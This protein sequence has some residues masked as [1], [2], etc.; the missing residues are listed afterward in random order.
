L[1]L[2]SHFLKA[3]RT[4]PSAYRREFQGSSSIAGI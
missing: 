1:S 4:S 2:R 3:F